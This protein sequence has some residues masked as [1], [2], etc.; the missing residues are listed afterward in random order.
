MYEYLIIGGGITGVALGRLLQKRGIE[1]FLIL[2]SS[3]HAG[4]L[5]RS[6]EI[7]GHHL[8][9]GGGHFLCTKYPEVYDFIFEHLPKSDL[10][11]FSRVSKVQLGGETIDYPVESNLWQLSLE[12][13]IDFVL[14]TLRNGQSRDEAEPTNYREWI[15]WKL[16]EQIAT[17][18]MLPYNEKIW[19]VGPEEMAI[20]WLQ[21]IPVIDAKEV[22]RACLSREMDRKYM[23]SHAGFYYPKRG[24]FQTI[25]DAIHAPVSG[26]IAL[27]EPVAKLEKKSDHWLVNGRYKAVNVVNTAP[28]PG[29]WEAL[30]APAHLREDFDRLRS[31]SI[32]VSLWERPYAHDWH[33]LYLPDRAKPH[34]RELFIHNFAPHSAPAG[35]YTET[36]IKRWPEGGKWAGGAPLFEHRNDA[37]YPIPVLGHARAIRGVLDYYRPMQLFGLGRWGQWQYFNSDVCIWEAMRWVRENVGQAQSSAI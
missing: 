5:C 30:G 9:L 37:A 26:N 17:Q 31:N 13:Q 18:Y 35:M 15:F 23:P 10:N 1:N 12:N 2:E 14:A 11:W 27:C 33:W 36:N 25:F 7:S 24:G 22:L 34:H 19:G 21:K 6:K 3:P 20:D 29:L 4:G 32:V 8:D 16:G 28:W